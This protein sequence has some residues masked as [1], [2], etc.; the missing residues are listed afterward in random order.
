MKDRL[1]TFPDDEI[2]SIVKEISNITDVKYNVLDSDDDKILI[3]ATVT[4][5]I[6]DNDIM[7][8]VIECFKERD[9]LKSQIE[10]LRKE[11]EDIRRQRDKVSSEKSALESKNRELQRQIDELK[12]QID[13]L[14]RQITPQVVSKD[15]I[16]LANQKLYEA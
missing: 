4:A 1:L 15:K 10:S 7:N 11:N 16:A 8:Y 6:D 12:R 13:E 9:E 3:R 5:Q 14:K 2:L